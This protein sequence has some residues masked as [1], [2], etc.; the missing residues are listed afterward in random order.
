MKLSKT[1]SVTK[2]N[3]LLCK[4]SGCGLPEIPTYPSSETI[5]QKVLGPKR[6]HVDLRMAS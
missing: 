4:Y 2:H 3:E 5:F 6:Q 1:S